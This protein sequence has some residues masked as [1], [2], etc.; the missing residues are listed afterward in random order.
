MLGPVE[1]EDI[2]RGGYGE[3]Q[4]LHA[5]LGVDCVYFGPE[6]KVMA[7][8]T[9]VYGLIPGLVMVAE[10]YQKCIEHYCDGERT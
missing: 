9:D 10:V 4:L 1:Y 5:R 2:G 8:Q 6:P 7:H 3:G